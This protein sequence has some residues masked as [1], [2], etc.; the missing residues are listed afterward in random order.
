MCLFCRMI[1]YVEH[2]HEH[3]EDPVIMQGG[4]YKLPSKPGYST[5]MKEQSLKKFDY[6][7]GDEW[8]KLFQDGIY[9]KP[10]KMQ[11]VH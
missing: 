7:K 10:V 8:K 3:F 9:F 1:E 6:P 5:K 4:R 11:C 2:L